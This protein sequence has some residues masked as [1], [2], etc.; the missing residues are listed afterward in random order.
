MLRA[1]LETIEEEEEEATASIAAANEM[2][3]DVQQPVFSI[4]DEQRTTTSFR[5]EFSSTP[6]RIIA[7]HGAA[8]LPSVVSGRNWNKSQW[9][10]LIGPLQETR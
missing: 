6:Q 3:V 7:R 9:K 8:T 2:S 1:A 4:K 5:K 10:N